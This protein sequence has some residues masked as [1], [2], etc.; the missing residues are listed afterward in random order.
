MKLLR[1]LLLTALCAALPAPAQDQPAEK[2]GQP[3]AQTASPQGSQNST[4]SDTTSSTTDAVQRRNAEEAAAALKGGYAKQPAAPDF[5]E[6]LVDLA[7]NLFDVDSS[8]NTPTRYA[9]SAMFLIIAIIVRRLVATIV[10][11]ILRKL[12]ARTKTTLDDKL[13]PALESPTAA[14]V[15]VAGAVAA[16]KALKLSPSGDHALSYGSTL[17]FSLVTFWFLLRAFNTVL[18]H[19]QEVARAK[20]MGIAAFMPWIKK[21]LVSIFIVFGVLIVAQSL[22]A[23][24]KAFLAGLG[25]GGLAFALAAQD[26]LANVFG[27]VVVA[28]D[29]PFKIGEFVQIGSNSGT[30]EDI[31]LRSTKLRRVDKALVVVPNKTVAAEAITNLSRFTQ[32]RV[33]QTLGLTYDATPDQVE[34]FVEEV[35]AKLQSEPEIEKSSIIV[36]FTEFGDSS[37]NIW[38]V[39]LT[40]S[41]DFAKHLALK[42]RLNLW[43]MRTVAARGMSMAFPTR[44]LV[45]DGP[46]ARRLAEKVSPAQPPQP[47]A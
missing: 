15:V 46:V 9:V 1:I 8:G 31:G 29:Q 33:E 21:T 7:L 2:V 35:R 44:T 10:F 17:A 32:R 39:Y 14:F 4:T 18:D 41:S 43:I 30:V 26:T 37:I 16:L 42:Q 24:V 25:I 45:L 47:Q 11:G 3:A 20:N 5:L 23:D 27:S 6:H 13:F 12:A 19:A 22:G 36:Q 38:M 40:I 28:I 34:S